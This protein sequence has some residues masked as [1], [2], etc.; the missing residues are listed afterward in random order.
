VDIYAGTYVS[1]GE[2]D[3]SG[4]YRD[5]LSHFSEW[6]VEAGRVAGK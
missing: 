1:K 3:I 5:V 6:V 2:E 4:L